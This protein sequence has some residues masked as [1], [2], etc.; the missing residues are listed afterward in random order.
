[1][2]GAV[3]FLAAFAAA[4]VPP[5]PDPKKR[6]PLKLIDGDQAPTKENKGK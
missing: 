6:P 4:V 1:M 2:R 3:V 5:P